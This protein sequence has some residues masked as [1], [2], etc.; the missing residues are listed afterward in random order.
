MSLAGIHA[1]QGYDFQQL[2]ALQ[3]VVNLFTQDDIE[4][5]Q[6]ESTGIPGESNEVTV[7]DVVII[8][9]DKTRKYIQAKKNQTHYKSWSL[10]DKTIKDELPKVL[11]QLKQGKEFI[12][13]FVSRSSFGNLEKLTKNCL[14]I[15]SLS[16]L[17]S[18]GPKS[19]LN[20]LN[21]LSAIWGADLNDTF[22]LVQHITYG[23]PI[24]DEERLAY[25]SSLLK[26]IVAHPDLAILYLKDLVNEYTVKAKP[27]KH[28][29]R[30]SDVIK[31]L[32][33]N[34]IFSAPEF[35]N[36]KIIAE[37]KTLSQIGRQWQRDI[38]GIKIERH[39]VNTI[40]NLISNNTKTILLTSMP[41]SGKTCVLLDL[42]DA[43]DSSPD[44]LAFLKGDWPLW[45]NIEGG[46]S[47]VSK[48]ARLSESHRII[49]VID[50]LDVLSLNREHNALK[51]F[52][53]LVDQLSR[54]PNIIIIAACRSFD[55]QYDPLLR[56]RK[57]EQVIELG[58]LNY[59]LQVAPLL[60]KWNVDVDTLTN[61]LK[62]LLVNPRKLAL[63]S[64]IASRPSS[65][66]LR[67]GYELDELFIQELIVKN[68]GLGA[69]A[70]NALY[71]LAS[72]MAENRRHTLDES[73][74]AIDPNIQRN[75]ISNGV[76]AID[77]NNRIF[78][79][80]QSL[81]ETISIRSAITKGKSLLEFILSYPPL[82]YIRPLIRAF[83]FQLRSQS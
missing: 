6:I 81:Y 5:I 73:I 76:I 38:D 25:I 49:L 27:G 47:F 54:V 39:E 4:A 20:D 15:S 13:E 7:D 83:F 1:S 62:N 51:R 24:N 57:W 34:G 65:L 32:N 79:N 21:K 50:A 36:S 9:K 11:T 48:C 58:D 59:D 74:A 45:D 10:S 75:L 55:A 43:I 31:F 26:S 68:V 53:T 77:K 71:S 3:W 19:T 42:C 33:S 30:K 70:L 52:L 72:K 69:S 46:G 40:L 16:H 37:L 23:S 82:P 44:I 35:D 78:F 67:S 8:Y 60:N 80:H 22:N 63:F 29:L 18:N 28:I 14:L 2:I 61:D 12:V 64:M 56:N 17:K 41:G 66:K